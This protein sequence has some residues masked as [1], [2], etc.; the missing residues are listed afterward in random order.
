MPDTPRARALG[1]ELRAARKASGLTMRRLGDLIG[2]SEAKVSRMETARRRLAPH[3]VAA[4]LDALHL[5]GR[6]RD[7]LLRL[8]QDLDRSA[9]WESGGGLPAQL[10]ELADAETRAVRITEVSEVLIPGLLQIPEYSRALFAA[11]DVPPD[12]VERLVAARLAR[13]SALS[14]A[15]PVE[16][17]VLLDEAA[18]CRAVGGAA[19]MAEQ[20]RAVGKA[21]RMPNVELR[22]VPFSV[23]AHTG[24]DGPFLLLEFCRDRPLVHVEQRRCGVFLEDPDDVAPFQR[25]RSR[26]V[27]T[28]MSPDRSAELVIAHAEAY[29]REEDTGRAR[30]PLA[31]VQLQR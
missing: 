22:V 2:C 12:N 16:Y 14:A 18:L 27:R 4:Y 5:R 31:E 24:L 26:L 29:E 19:V 6:E 13:Q 28:A 10:T 20:L 9:W 25:A 3:S 7:R 8:A 15:D 23:G 11:T 17:R 1:K 30:D 21:A